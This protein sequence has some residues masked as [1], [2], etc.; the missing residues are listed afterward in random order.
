MAADL[1]VS[2]F[3]SKSHW[4]TVFRDQP[5]PYSPILCHDL[6]LVLA[7]KN[8][9][10]SELIEISQDGDELGTLVPPRAT[11]IL[12]CIIARDRLFVRYLDHG[13]TTIESWDFEGSPLG[14]VAV[15]FSGTVNLLPAHTQNS[16]SFFYSYQSYD[17]P[18]AIFEYSVKSGTSSLWH[19]RDLPRP[20]R[21]CSIRETSFIAK[22]GTSIP[23]SLVSKESESPSGPRPVIMTSYGGFGMAMTPQFSVLVTIMMELGAVFVLPHI[24][25]GGEFGKAWHE[26]G[27]GRY[28]QTAFNDFIAA[29]EWLC[30]EGIATPEKLAIFGGSNSGLIVAGAMTQ[31]PDLFAAVLSIAPLIDMVRYEQ[32]DEAARW[33]GEFGTAEDPDDFRAL[34]SYSPYHRVEVTINYPATLFV[35]GDRDERCNP[36]HVRKM[37][38]RLQEREAQSSPIILDYCE[39][40]GHSPLLPLSVRIQALARRIAFLCRQMNIPLTDGGNRE[41]SYS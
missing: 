9:G 5:V 4:R 31:R 32:F 3:G 20:T 10:D 41:S 19:Q 2:P 6:I 11:P 33:R 21:P 23:V 29:A 26:A 18:P 8:S 39:Q 22:D 38:A 34:Y 27:R 30:R 36:A 13:V 35:S 15:P 25:G 40:R 37:V 7:E 24:R 12:Q 1:S 16:D 17:C 14:S 28:K